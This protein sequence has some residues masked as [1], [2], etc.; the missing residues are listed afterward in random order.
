MLEEE[1]NDRDGHIRR[2]ASPAKG[3]ISSAKRPL[4]VEF[5][6]RSKTRR[7]SFRLEA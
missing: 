2:M 5:L 3:P 7:L 1:C 4:A 6:S